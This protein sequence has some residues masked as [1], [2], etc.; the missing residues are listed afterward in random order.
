MSLLNQLGDSRSSR[1]AHIARTTIAAAVVAATAFG[2]AGCAA[3]D[4]GTTTV[5]FFSWE[6]EDTMKPIIDAFEQANPDIKIQLSTAT[7]PQ[8]YATTLQTRLVAG[9]AEDVFV[10]GD[11]AA[12]AGGGLLLD[13]TDEPF[14]DDLSPA[15]ISYGSYEDR[16]YG[17]SISSWGGGLVVN[18]DLLASVGITEP[19]TNWDGFLDQLAT[20]QDAGITPLYEA[21]DGGV[22]NTLCALLGLE[23]QEAGGDLDQQVFDGETTWAEHWTEPFEQWMRI[24]DEGYETR[25]V[26]GLSGDVVTSEFGSGNVAMIGWGSWGVFNL[27]D[28]DPDFEFEFWPV[29]GIEEGTSYW[30]GA[31][32]PAY[33]INA[34][35]DV[36]EAA[37]KFVEFMASP[38]GS[39]IFNAETDSIT[40]TAGFEP[41]VDP[42][43][44]RMVD[45]VRE[46]DIYLPI[47]NWLKYQNALDAE[48][49]ILL[50]Q[51][52]QGEIEPADVPAGLDAKLQELDR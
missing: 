30:C 20:L 12:Q 17:V 27:Y 48:S 8:E 19:A 7:T 3:A 33:S 43:L 29:P 51:M 47:I 39:Q 32:S 9:T 21:A 24:F 11:K 52:I 34:A 2:I 22:S 46:G 50:Q 1:A 25:D 37:L 44:A 5:R 40:T 15:N 4:D 6:N 45:P 14:V 23:N 18:K 36:K 16:L 35:T 10:I 49:I 31:P 38:E 42:A 26:V 28:L 41:D 13:L